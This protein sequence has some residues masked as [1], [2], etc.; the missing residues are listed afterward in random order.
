MEVPGL[1]VESE[2]QLLTYAT[3]TP[4]PSRVCDLHHSSWQHRTF[5]LLSKAR[6]RT[7]IFVDTSQIRLCWAMMRTPSLLDFSYT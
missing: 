5:N 7:C 3:A 2:L 1:G 6:D 4:D